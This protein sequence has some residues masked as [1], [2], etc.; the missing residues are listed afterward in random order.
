MGIDLDWTLADFSAIYQMA[1]KSSRRL[2]PAEL[3]A[4][5]DTRSD[6][7]A[8]I[9]FGL[10]T[11]LYGV[12]GQYPVLTDAMWPAVLKKLKIYG[13]VDELYLVS[14]RSDEERDNIE[15]WLRRV[16]ILDVFDDLFL[17]GER[18]SK[19]SRRIDL[20]VDDSFGNCMDM[21][22]SGGRAILWAKDILNAERPVAFPKVE[23][24]YTALQVL[25]KIYRMRVRREI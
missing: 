21:V 6:Y 25:S 3:K 18:A 14:L 8:D 19:G 13:Y 15:D 24:A 1:L 5:I 9:V 22:E 2:A 16:N 10:W 11:K 7:T 17:I 20:L 23:V 12:N 4:I